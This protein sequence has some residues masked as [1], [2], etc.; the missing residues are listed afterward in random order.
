MAVVEL[1]AARTEAVGHA[2]ALERAGRPAAPL[3]VPV[4]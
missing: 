1:R 3:D 2:A 4:A